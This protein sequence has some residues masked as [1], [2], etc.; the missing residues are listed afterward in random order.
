MRRIRRWMVSV[1]LLGA[2]LGLPGCWDQHPVETRAAVTAIG[3]D[4]GPQ[5]G[6]QRYTLTFPNVTTTTSSLATTQAGQQF[7]TVSVVA[8]SLLP[9]LAAAQ[10]QES[11]TLYL[12]QVRILCLSTHLPRAIWTRTLTAMADSGRFVMTTWVVA[13]PLARAVVTLTP[14]VEVVPEVGL[15]Q[16]LACHCQGIRWPGRAWRVWAESV[17]PGVSAAVTAVVPL[18]PQFQLT[19][20]AVL[21]PHRLVLWSTAA[22]AGWA[23]LTGRVVHDVMTVSVQHAPVV[24]SLIRGTAHVH[25]RAQGPDVTAV[26]SLRYSGILLGEPGGPDALRRDRAVELTMAHQIQRRVQ[27]AWM[28]AQVTDTDPMGWHRDAAWSDPQAAAA[29]ARWQGWSLETTVHFTLR[30]EGNVR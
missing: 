21:G 26:A 30:E 24:V 25:F 4:P 12:G 18:R 27:A 20:I 1:G 23:Y 16:A 17:T 6:E 15:Y 9:A 14:P 11:R 29:I 7:Y 28:A 22:T 10:R 19:R 13:A 2:V 5:P 8:P 3:I